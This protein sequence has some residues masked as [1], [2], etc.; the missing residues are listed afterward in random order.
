MTLLNNLKIALKIGIIVG[1]LALVSLG[2][3]GLAGHQ[4]RSVDDSY[5]DIIGHLDKSSTMAARA[6]RAGE[7]YLSAA[8]QL[9]VETTDEGNAAM[10][11]AVKESQ[12]RYESLMQQ[13]RG[14]VPDQASLIDP[15]V[16][17]FQGVFATCAP[18]I[19]FA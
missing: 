6:A 11:A 19:D 3:V 16:A 8:Y 14:W 15:V 13:V 4:L 7:A 9:A 12:S 5:S 10:L 1:L 17:R 18:A 2:A